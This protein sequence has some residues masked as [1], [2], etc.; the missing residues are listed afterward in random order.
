MTSATHYT[1]FA[2]SGLVPGDSPTAAAATVGVRY[3]RADQ[4]TDLHLFDFIPQG[5]AVSVP[6]PTL[7]V[8]LRKG[9]LRLAVSF[10]SR[11][12]HPTEA[13]L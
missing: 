12:M 5:S 10:Y 3:F 7:N 8:Q 9:T 11:I 2:Y 6:W 13:C 1:Q 4:T